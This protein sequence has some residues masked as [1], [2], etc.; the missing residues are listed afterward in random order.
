MKNRHTVVNALKECGSD[1]DEKQSFLEL[2]Y[3]AILMRNFSA[4]EI[5]F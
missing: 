3:P 2:D 5:A 1:I 4:T